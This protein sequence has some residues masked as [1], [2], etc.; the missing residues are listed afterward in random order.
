[1]RIIT[2]IPLKPG[3]P[4]TS[5]RCGA[6]LAR[7]RRVAF[8]PD[9][10]TFHR[11]WRR[12][13]EHLR[14]LRRLVG[15]N[16][17]EERAPLVELSKVHAFTGVQVLL[18][19][20]H[21]PLRQ[22][23]AQLVGGCLPPGATRSNLFGVL[24]GALMRPVPAVLDAVRWTLQG[25]SRRPHPPAIALHARSMTDKTRAKNLTFYERRDQVD[26][27]LRCYAGALGVYENKNWVHIDTHMYYT[28][29]RHVYAL[30]L[31]LIH[32]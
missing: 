32:I 29:G 12:E 6:T 19:S 18:K 8:T 4:S 25:T 15:V 31:S 21:R 27:G 28:L 17:L 10:C 22:R 20:V 13:K 5:T 26:T 11:P 16:W 2:K 3:S 7:S 30:R 14:C 1:M 24:L 9:K 23:V